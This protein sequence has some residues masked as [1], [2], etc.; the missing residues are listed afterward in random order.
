[1]NETTS[2]AED[3]EE[4]AEETTAEQTTVETIETVV[5]EYDLLGLSEGNYNDFQENE[6]LFSWNLGTGKDLKIHMTKKKDMDSMMWNT[7]IRQPV[8]AAVYITQEK[9]VNRSREVLM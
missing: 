9:S 6:Q 3:V 5:P 1:M 4:T 7:I 8:G 2:E